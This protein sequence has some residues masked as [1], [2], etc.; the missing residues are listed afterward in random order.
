MAYLTWVF[1]IL[2]FVVLLGFAARNVD[3]VHVRGFLG[4]E[5][6]A[7]LALVMLVTLACGAAI[8]VL[9]AIST[10]LALRR[11][12]APP[13]GGETGA[14]AAARP[15]PGPLPPSELQRGEEGA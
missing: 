12:V 9:G 8:G 1:R 2:L 3:P 7:P 15:S 13:P 6:Q 10:A 5:W 4:Y 14:P 11:P